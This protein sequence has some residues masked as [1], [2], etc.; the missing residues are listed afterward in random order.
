MC[1][2]LFTFGWLFFYFFLFPH[3]HRC[4]VFFADFTYGY[5][6]NK[7]LCTVFDSNESQPEEE[8]TEGEEEEEVKKLASTPEIHSKSFMVVRGEFFTTSECKFIQ[9]IY[10]ILWNNLD[11][12]TKICKCTEIN[13]SLCWT[14]RITTT[15]K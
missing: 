6:R 2:T 8:T 12:P 15:K 5:G 4:S 14:T 13:I 10:R 3:C 9:K 11:A 1:D 7:D